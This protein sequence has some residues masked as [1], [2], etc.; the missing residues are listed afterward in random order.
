MGSENPQSDLDLKKAGEN[1]QLKE[2]VWDIGGDMELF[3]E[4]II[5]YYPQVEG[6]Y[7]G[8]ADSP[9][10]VIVSLFPSPPYEYEES[11][12]AAQRRNP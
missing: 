7:H 10:F 4:E 8:W 1:A 2:S 12:D 5:N 6:I 11:F 3:S 9:S